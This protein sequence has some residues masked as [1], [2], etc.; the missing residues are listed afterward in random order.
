MLRFDPEER[1]SAEQA[2]KHT[3]LQEYAE[4]YND[5]Y[6]DK[7]EKFQQEWEG[8]EIKE[9]EMKKLVFREI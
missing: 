1:I 3:F 7:N 9:D 5:D 2:L 8:P 6:P 4:Y